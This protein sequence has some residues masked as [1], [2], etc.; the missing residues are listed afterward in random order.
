MFRF[1]NPLD[2]SKDGQNSFIDGIRYHIRNSESIKEEIL[3]NLDYYIAK[4]IS[5]MGLPLDSAED[6]LDFILKQE[7]INADELI[8]SDERELLEAIGSKM[9]WIG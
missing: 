5:W 7:N 4:Q 6:Y 9:S 3:S 1:E 2:P 8:I